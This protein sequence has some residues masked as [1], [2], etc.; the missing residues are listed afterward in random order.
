MLQRTVGGRE[1]LLLDV[2]DYW[3]VKRKKWGKPIL[4]R[5]QAP[6]SASD[7]NPFLVFR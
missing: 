2:Y 5:L 6:T 4:R 1:E 3:V 7:S